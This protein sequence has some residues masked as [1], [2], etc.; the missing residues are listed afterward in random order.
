M[1]KDAVSQDRVLTEAIQKE[2]AFEFKEFRPF[3]SHKTPK[4]VVASPAKIDPNAHFKKVA[5]DILASGTTLQE[6]TVPEVRKEKFGYETTSND[7]GYVASWC[8]HVCC[9][10]TTIVN[11]H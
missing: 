9:R 2:E 5:A 6:A 11:H 4:E 10:C 7:V 3:Q 1:S 8:F